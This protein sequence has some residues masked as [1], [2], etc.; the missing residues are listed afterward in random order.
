MITLFRVIRL[1][2]LKVKWKLAIMQ[3]LDRQTMNIIKHPEEIEKKI[4]PYLAEL[5]HESNGNKTN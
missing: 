4:L 1:Y 3:E 5:I 2:Q